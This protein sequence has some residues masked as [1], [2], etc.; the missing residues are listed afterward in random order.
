VR[1]VVLCWSALISV[2]QEAAMFGSSS[3]LAH[4]LFVNVK[5]ELQQVSDGDRD[6]DGDGDGNVNNDSHGHGHDHGRVGV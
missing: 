4:A 1:F 6:S 2:Q 3:V 5:A